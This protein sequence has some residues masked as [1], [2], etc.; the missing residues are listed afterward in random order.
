M[1][2]VTMKDAEWFRVHKGL[3]NEG[4]FVSDISA[5]EVLQGLI[6]ETFG[7][8]FSKSGWKYKRYTN[9]PTKNSNTDLYR[10][11]YE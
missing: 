9:S 10:R 4:V 7:L 1:G 3:K 11:I 8:K 6:C 2:S 5:E